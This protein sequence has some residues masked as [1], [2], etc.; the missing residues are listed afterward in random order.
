MPESKTDKF[1]TDKKVQRAE[2]SQAIHWTD[3]TAEKIIR[4][5]G[6]E[7][8]NIRNSGSNAEL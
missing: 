6:K 4:E 1:K 3:V 8:E 7:R 5:K 2:D